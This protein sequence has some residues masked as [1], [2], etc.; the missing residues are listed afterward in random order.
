MLPAGLPAAACT[1]AA[2]CLQARCCFTALVASRSTCVP[3]LTSCTWAWRRM[4]AWLGTC[5]SWRSLAGWGGELHKQ[6]SEVDTAAVVQKYLQRQVLAEHS[7][8]GSAGAQEAQQ[9]HT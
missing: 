9:Q 7:W 5:R 8:V 2:A 4:W 1:A 6:R 3:A